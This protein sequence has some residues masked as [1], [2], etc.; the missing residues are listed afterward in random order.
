MP[1]RTICDVL[2][3]MRECTKTLNFSYLSSLIEEAQHL[4]NRME[5]SLWDQK[6]FKYAQKRHKKLKH[7]IAKME[8][9]VNDE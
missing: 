5:A 2:S 8:E 9:V 1:N 7:E 4:V 6:D 3:S